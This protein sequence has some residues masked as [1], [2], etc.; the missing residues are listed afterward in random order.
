[1]PGIRL[2]KYSDDGTSSNEQSRCNTEIRALALNARPSV[3]RT[4]CNMTDRDAERQTVVHC[5]GCC[6]KKAPR[7]MLSRLFLKVR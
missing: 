2:S 7:Q 1:M 5:C 6:H 3:I 4:S